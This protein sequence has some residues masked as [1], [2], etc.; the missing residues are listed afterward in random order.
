MG[1]LHATAEENQAAEQ[2]GTAEPVVGEPTVDAAEPEN[3]ETLETPAVA[4]QGPRQSGSVHF[5]SARKLSADEGQVS[6]N[7]GDWG[8]PE[9]A[10]FRTLRGKATIGPRDDFPARIR[11]QLRAASCAET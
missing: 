8:L 5:P 2:T 11:V 9:G 10:I 4:G 1:V 3:D 7:E 6:W